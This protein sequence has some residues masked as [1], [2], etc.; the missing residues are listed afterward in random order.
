[1][2]S[3]RSA[4]VTGSTG[5]IGSALVRGL[6]KQGVEV[7]CLVR[8]KQRSAAMPPPTGA[9]TIEI[10]AF[11]LKVLRVALADVRTDVVFNLAAYGVQPEDRNPQL[12]IEGNITLV[13]NL[14]EAVADWPVR[15]FLHTGSCAE[16]GR[17]ARFGVPIAESQLLLP[18]SPYGAAKAASVL[19]GTALASRLEIPFNT[20]RLFG[21]FGPAEA[22]S[23][24]VPYLVDRL[25]RN[26]SVDLTEGE[27]IRDLLLDEDAAQAFIAAASA[28][29]L[30]QYAVYNVC[31]SRPIRIREVGIA[32]ADVL[33]K[34]HD[35][36]HWGERRYR[37]DEPM[38]LVGDNEKFVG[39]TGWQPRV[40]LEDGIRQVVRTLV[41]TQASGVSHGF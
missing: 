9:R 21:V 28:E 17:S 2:K 1:M 8:K 35:L 19:L 26:Q 15:R 36:L 25:V 5:F 6:L 29:E 27:Q 10:P 30:E 3:L 23:R 24:L 32:V 37:A 22:P 33:G 31:S 7:T 4:L 40:S 18:T 11:D 13:A 39:A 20:L 14:L 16:Y 12:L 38:W 41:T 34:P